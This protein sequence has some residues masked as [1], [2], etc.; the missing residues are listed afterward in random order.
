MGQIGVPPPS[1][2]HGQPLEGHLMRLPFSHRVRQYLTGAHILRGLQSAA[3][4]QQDGSPALRLSQLETP[5][6]TNSG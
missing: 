5:V 6:P 1:L 4:P 3:S 2:L